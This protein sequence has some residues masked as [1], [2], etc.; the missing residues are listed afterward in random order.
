MFGIG[1][2]TPLWDASLGLFMYSILMRF[3]GIWNQDAFCSFEP[4]LMMLIIIA[5][6]ASP[7]STQHPSLGT[8][9]KWMV[10]G[11]CKIQVSNG[12]RVSRVRSVVHVHMKLVK[13][14]I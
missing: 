13:L 2:Y 4:E 8:W 7:S 3:V 14:R 5:C 10:L 9:A 12:R 6:F 1:V 11:I